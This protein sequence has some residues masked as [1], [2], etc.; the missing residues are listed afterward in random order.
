MVVLWILAIFAASGVVL[1]L[2]ASSKSSGGR[3]TKPDK[4]AIYSS[5][6]AERADKAK[7]AEFEKVLNSIDNY[8]RKN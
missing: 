5:K 4:N 2:W 6:A 3:N 8:R 1:V 7:K